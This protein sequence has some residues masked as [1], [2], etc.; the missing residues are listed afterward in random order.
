MGNFPFFNRYYQCFVVAICFVNIFRRCICLKIF[1]VEN[2]GSK[3]I[4]L[5]FLFFSVTYASWPAYSN[6]TKDPV[7]FFRRIE[8]A[9]IIYAFEF[10]DKKK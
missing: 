4:T 2:H 7:G 10:E 9:A 5:F 6:D 8:I 3:I 1:F